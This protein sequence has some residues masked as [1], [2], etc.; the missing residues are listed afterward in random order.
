MIRTCAGWYV[1]PDTVS[2]KSASMEIT[3][4]IIF[5]GFGR[6]CLKKNWVPDNQVSISSF[7]YSEFKKTFTNVTDASALWVKSAKLELLV[8]GLRWP[9]YHRLFGSSHCRSNFQMS[10]SFLWI[11]N[12]RNF[13]ITSFRQ[14][15]K[16][17]MLMRPSLWLILSVQF[18]LLWTETSSR[19]ANVY[20]QIKHCHL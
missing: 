12:H 7:C 1:Q 5:A 16:S 18:T 10:D 2:K 17:R 14:I 4:N 11:Q 20:K 15:G 9:C 3:T 13:Y 19:Q 6:V 8:C